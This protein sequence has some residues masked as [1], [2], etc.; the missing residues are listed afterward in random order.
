MIPY[1]RTNIAFFPNRQAMEIFVQF[2]V[3]H[4]LVQAP[5]EGYCIYGQLKWDL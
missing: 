2:K 5:D 3:V 4:S 1:N